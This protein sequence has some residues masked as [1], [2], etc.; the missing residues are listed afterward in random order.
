MGSVADVLW[1]R[2]QPLKTNADRMQQEKTFVCAKRD[3]RVFITM[4]DYWKIPALQSDYRRDAGQ[5]FA[6]SRAGEN[7]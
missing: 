1:N 7:D 5:S 2:P 3:E 4:S 6:A